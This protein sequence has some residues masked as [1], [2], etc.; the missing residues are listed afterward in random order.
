MPRAVTLSPAAI[1]A[2]WA[3]CATT[4]GDRALRGRTRD[5]NHPGGRRDKG[6]WIFRPIGRPSSVS[7]A[8][9]ARPA[10]GRGGG[11]ADRPAAAK[12]TPPAPPPPTAPRWTPSE[13]GFGRAAG[14]GGLVGQR[15][16]NVAVYGPTPRLVTV[17]QVI[18][19]PSTTSRTLSLLGPCAAHLPAF[20]WAAGLATIGHRLRTG[21]APTATRST[22]PSGSPGQTGPGTC[23]VRRMG[24]TAGQQ[25]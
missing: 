14:I 6:A 15:W 11:G 10:S 25:T 17:L 19:S 23:A 12:P 21:P 18:C 13:D 16:R 9:R 1:T 8:R 22:A 4:R 7:R 3:R 20:S 24:S 2:A 5:G